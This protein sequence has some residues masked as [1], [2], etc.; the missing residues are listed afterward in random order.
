MTAAATYSALRTYQRCV[1]RLMADPDV[2]GDLLLVGLWLARATILREPPTTTGS[3]WQLTD[4]ASALYP[5]VDLPE[6]TGLGVTRPAYYGPDAGRVERVLRDDIRRYDAWAEAGTPRGRF[7]PCA[8]PM[9]RRPICG[10]PTSM[11]TFLTDIATGRRRMLGACRKHEAW[12]WAEVRRNRAEVAGADVPAPPANAGGVLARYID[13]D[14][15]ALWRG[16]DPDWT[17][18]AEEL[19][20]PAPAGPPKLTLVVTPEVE[21]SRPAAERRRAFAVLDGGAS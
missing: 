19:A 6:I 4:I 21:L 11:G 5:P 1:A 12:Y 10:K 16:I 18:P 9:A 7:G 2:T 20:R 8:G 3:G 13:I 17:P 14:W 15:P